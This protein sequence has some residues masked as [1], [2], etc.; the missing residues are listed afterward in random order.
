MDTHTTGSSPGTYLRALQILRPSAG[1]MRR[2]V[3]YLCSRLPEHGVAC[4]LAAPQRIED[5]PETGFRRLPVTA[6]FSPLADAR[7]ALRAARLYREADLVHA[8]GMRGTWIAT[9]AHSLRPRP[10]VATAHNLP[11]AG[12][13]ARRWVMAVALT[14]VRVLVCVSEAVAQA[15]R[16][17]LGFRGE[18]RVIPNGIPLAGAPEHLDRRSAKA[19]L[20]LDAD[21]P[22]VLAV[23]RLSPE[24]GFDILVKACARLAPE[25]V[26]ICIVGDGPQRTDLKGMVESRGMEEHVRL[27]GY[28]AAVDPWYQAADVV[29]APSRLEGQGLAALEA[30][31]WETPVV[32][33]RVGGLPEVVDDG[34]TGL[35]VAPEDPDALAQAIEELLRDT[36]R[37]RAMGRAGRRR[38]EERF[39][40]EDMIRRIADLYR[41]VT[42]LP[43]TR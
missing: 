22:L 15:F 35:L 32:A 6:A 11:E 41:E 29:V 30:M 8:H 4:T 43:A 37:A 18:T 3:G 10:L 21:R 38:V 39:R 9:L 23:G 1:G 24:K 26:A 42:G 5:V 16:E 19:R 14:R 2:H 20:G 13:A 7:C 17:R 27:V 12:G 31:A 34:V 28:V 33:S 40:L 25:R 36:S